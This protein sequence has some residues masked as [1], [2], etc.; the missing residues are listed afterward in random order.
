[1]LEHPARNLPQLG[2]SARL[3]TALSSALAGGLRDSIAAGGLLLAYVGLEWLSFLHEHEGV[4]V[5]PWNP[6]LGAA[7]AFLVMRGAAYGIVLFAGVLAA[8]ILVLRSALAW[9]VIL[10]IASL[11]AAS[12]TAVAAVI[13]RYPG[14]DARLHR[15][16]TVL[17]LLAAGA[18]GAFLATASVSLLLVASRELKL[19]DLM[20]ASL[21]LFVGD[22]I[23]IAVVTPLVLR[24]SVRGRNIAGRTLA[25]LVP[26]ILFYALLTGFAIWLIVGSASQ[27]QYKFL[28]LLFL[29]VVAASVR[30]GIDG[31]CLALATTQLALVAVLHQYGYEAS[32]FTEFQLVML[33]LTTSGLLVGVVVSEREQAS[34]V[35][36]QA[37]LRLKQMQAEAARAARI[38]LVS[39]MASALAHEISQPMTA[40]RA[41]ARSVQEIMSRPEADLRRA[42]SNVAALVSQIDHA[43][44]VVR[45][46][47]EFLR[48]GQ[49]HYSTLDATAL[50]EEALVLVRAEAAAHRV[51]IA[52]DIKDRLPPFF[53]DRIQIQQVLLNLAHNAIEAVVESGRTDGLIRIGARY[54]PEDCVLEFSVLDNGVGIPPGQPLFEPLSSTKAEGL[55]LGL[56]ICA[57]IVQAH[58]GRIWLESGVAGATELRFS[59]PVQTKRPA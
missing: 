15:V 30:H 45:R 55:G 35:A 49:P 22:L 32:A 1:M 9:P 42:G 28:S 31:S 5:T 56:S 33:I 12:Y 23:G 34:F 11:V 50:L 8:E 16:G 6:G 27:D 40:A 14:F 7:F 57:A 48:R 20:Q 41:L 18:A 25:L 26:E 52:L 39:S 59:L 58:G 38:N 17:T 13:R 29:P 47:R 21:P 37:E 10:G 19:A 44:G 2:S 54:V 36:R 4:P 51:R 46:M 24:L 53:G 43:A 3:R